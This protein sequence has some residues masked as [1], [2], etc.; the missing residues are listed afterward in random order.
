M[1]TVDYELMGM[2]A[3]QRLLDVGCG[4]GRH[5]WAAYSLYDCQVLGLDMLETDL[6]KTRFALYTAD[7]S[8][9]NGNGNC[10]LAVRGDAAK[11]PLKDRSFDRVICSEVLEHV[12]DDKSTVAELVRVLKDDG[13]IA[14]SVPTRL[15]ESIYW[16]ISKQYSRNPGGH[17][18][19]YKAKQIMQLLRDHNLEIF[20]VRHK[21]SLHSIYWLLRCLFGVNN[22]K[23]LVP[24]MYHSLLVWDLKTRTKPVRLLDDVCNHLFP[25]SIV[26][27]ARKGENGKRL[28]T[29]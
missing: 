6:Q 2:G 14:V 3:G 25:K 28:Q 11:L 17:V 7:N 15:T 4:N 21:H 26:I 10:W 19:I 24:R 5:T 12:A 18:R 1:L 23:A 29:A 22:E 13:V 9:R 8:K 20:A 16:R 27:Y